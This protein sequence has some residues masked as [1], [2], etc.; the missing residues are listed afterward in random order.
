MI[1][2]RCSVEF[3]PPRKDVV[4]CGKTCRNRAYKDR[5]RAS[6]TPKLK[7]L[8]LTGIRFG[9]L[10]VIE[11]TDERYNSFVVYLCLC[12][13][14]KTTKAHTGI[15]RSGGKRSCGCLEIE[16]RNRLNA[17]FGRKAVIHGGW[18]SRAYKSWISMKSRCSN[19]KDKIYGGRGIS[20]CSEWDASFEKFL[21]DMGNPP[22]G[23]TIDRIN[24]DKGYYKENCRW[25]TS[26]EQ[27]RSRT[28]NVYVD[29]NGE[30]VTVAEYAETLGMSWSGAEK[31]A[32]RE[33]IYIGRTGAGGALV[34]YDY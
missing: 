11:R 28:N 23:A 5:K 26:K 32:K 16:N 18:K 2:K 7:G 6:A 9:R 8:D 29:F 24:N 25:A 14:G 30:A 1:C 17:E 19:P 27:C 10:S 12:D 4:Y 31:K 20:V 13:C 3:I 22:P 21:S 34:K 33:G 15:L